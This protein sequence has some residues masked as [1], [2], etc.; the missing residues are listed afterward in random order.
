MEELVVFLF[1]LLRYA[2]TLY[3]IAIFIYI[4][5]SFV[6]GRD[7]AFGEMLGKL[8]EPYLEIFRSFIPPIGMIDLSPLIAILLLRFAGTGLISLQNMVLNWLF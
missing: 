4:I 3:T 6:G 7:S 2:L 1:T 8:V 5:M